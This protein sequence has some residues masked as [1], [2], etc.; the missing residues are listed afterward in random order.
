MCNRGKE[1]FK[2]YIK[3]KLG[4]NIATFCLLVSIEYRTL[5]NW[6]NNPKKRVLIDLIIDGIKW[7]NR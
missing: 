2:Q 6:Y 3:N 4:I 5:Y 7:R 1:T